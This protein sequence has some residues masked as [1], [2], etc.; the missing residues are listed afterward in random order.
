MLAALSE[1]EFK[2]TKLLSDIGK[3]SNALRTTKEKYRQLKEKYLN[4][5]RKYTKLNGEKMNKSDVQVGPDSSLDLSLVVEDLQRSKEDTEEANIKLL[6]EMEKLREEIGRSQYQMKAV[7][8]ANVVL[9]KQSRSLYRETEENKRV[10]V[11]RLRQLETSRKLNETLKQEKEVLEK[12][13]EMLESRVKEIEIDA[14]RAN[15]Q[16]D[17]YFAIKNKKEIELE[18]KNR[19]CAIYCH[20]LEKLKEENAFLHQKR[21]KLQSELEIVQQQFMDSQTRMNHDKKHVPPI[22]DF[23]GEVSKPNNRTNKLVLWK[24]PLFDSGDGNS[25]LESKTRESANSQSFEETRKPTP[26]LFNNVKVDDEK[27]G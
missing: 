7:R 6:R 10:D 2:N 24:S 21:K 12:E 14:R 17:G 16:C 25:L 20:Q 1:Y 23:D 18:E 3:A 4:L 11:D 9:M 27:V 26:V 19:E 5:S 13:V 15:E 8:K 22:V